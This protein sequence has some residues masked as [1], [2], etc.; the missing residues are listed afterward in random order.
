MCPNLSVILSTRTQKL[1][2]F[3]QTG[4]RARAAVFVLAD[5]DLFPR[6][7]SQMSAENKFVPDEVIANLKGE[8]LYAH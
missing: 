6:Q 4:F 2:S 1:Q 3:V 7:R 8:L 5:E